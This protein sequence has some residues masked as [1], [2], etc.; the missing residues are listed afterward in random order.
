MKW[1]FIWLCKS[2]LI[3]LRNLILQLEND[4]I[5]VRIVMKFLIAT[6]RK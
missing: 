2:F 3:L 1:N 5:C 4:L 6:I